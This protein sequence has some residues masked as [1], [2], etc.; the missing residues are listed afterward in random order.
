MQESIFTQLFARMPESERD[1]WRRQIQQNK[2]EASKIE[3]LRLELSETVLEAFWS[4]NPA[5]KK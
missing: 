1:K 2:K 4:A 5:P 3:L